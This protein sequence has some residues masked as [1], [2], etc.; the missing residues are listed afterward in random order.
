M[1]SGDLEEIDAVV[2]EGI[3]AGEMPGCVV[4][5]GRRGKIVFL[6]AYGDRQVEPERARMTTDT[7]FDMASLTKPVATATSVMILLQEGKL[8]LED[9]VAEHVPEFG[10]HG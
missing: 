8:R 7:V 2:A 6:K 4:M 1:R 3:E 5:I 10:N 9:R